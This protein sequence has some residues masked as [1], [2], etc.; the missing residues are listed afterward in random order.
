MKN[1]NHWLHIAQA[2]AAQGMKTAP[3]TGV[4][5]ASY[6]DPMDQFQIEPA[7]TN[8]VLGVPRPL[9][10]PGLEILR[11]W[12]VPAWEY[13]WTTFGSERHAVKDAKR[14]PSA[15]IKHSTFGIATTS[16]KQE[17]YS[18]KYGFDLDQFSAADQRLGIAE[19][20]AANARSIVEMAM[21]WERADLLTTAATYPAANRLAIGAG[22]EWDDTTPG[23][24]RDHVRTVVD[25][26]ADANGLD[27]EEISV[28]LP[29]E[30]Y[31]A[32]IADADFITFKRNQTTGLGGNA[33][34]VKAQNL[35]L[36]ASY[37][38]VGK[39]WTANMRYQNTAGVMVPMYGD[40]AIVYYDGDMVSQAWDISQGQYEFGRTAMWNRGIAQAPYMEEDTTTRWYPWHGYQEPLIT[41]SALAGII[42]NILT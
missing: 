23:D 26:V 17:R 11:P 28:F 14:G 6:A 36:L 9:G 31:R 2:L 32:A 21:E 25:A 37:W 12:Q 10:F 39:V 22:D 18:W 5:A 16:G 41:N 15:Q 40:V 3:F 38:E 4:D 20:C 13:R 1:P 8:L 7:L 30:V 24:P 29:R 27:D 33:F 19:K 42:T 34:T 35:Q